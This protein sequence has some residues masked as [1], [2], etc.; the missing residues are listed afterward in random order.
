M[1]EIPPSM[2]LERGSPL[3]LTVHPVMVGLL[4]L[5]MVPVTLMPLR[6]FETNLQL[7]NLGL[8]PST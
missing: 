3:S 4:G 2:N 7:S 1:K 6:A 5:M 8:H